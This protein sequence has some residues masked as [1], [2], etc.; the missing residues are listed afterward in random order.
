MRKKR[1]DPK[2]KENEAEYKREKILKEIEL[3]KQ[4]QSDPDV[5]QKDREYMRKK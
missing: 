4:K 3:K 2:V 1:S 5:K